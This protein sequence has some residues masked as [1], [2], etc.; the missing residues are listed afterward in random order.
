MTPALYRLGVAIAA[1]AIGLILGSALTGVALARQPH[2][3]AART[4]LLSAYREL[5]AALPDK[6]GHRDN[7][8]G[9]INQAI[10]QVN[11]GIASGR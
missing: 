10:G 3:F 11:A 4:D 1:L 8:M 9:L 6:G 2:M 5:H 7:A